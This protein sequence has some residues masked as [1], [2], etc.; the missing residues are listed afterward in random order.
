MSGLRPRVGRPGADGRPRRGGMPAAHPPRRQD[1]GS[2]ALI[3]F[4]DPDA[5]VRVAALAR[6]HDGLTGVEVIAGADCVVLRA[7][8]GTPVDQSAWA[9][10]LSEVL[11][12]SQTQAYDPSAT[13]ALSIDVAY[14]GEDLTAVASATG[15]SIAEV[16]TRHSDAEYLAAFAGFAPGFTYLTGLDPLLALP[17]RSTP[18]TSVPAGSVAIAVGYSAVYP[19]PS[20]GGWH[21]LGHTSAVLFDPRGNPPALI[22][23][24][25]RVRF[26]A[27][28]PEVRISD[29]GAGPVTDSITAPT[30]ASPT[31]REATETSEP[32]EASEPVGSSEPAKPAL[33]VISAGPLAL[34]VDAG[35]PGWADSG[36]GRSGAYDLGALADANAAVGNAADAAAIEV[37]LGPLRF[38]ALDPITVAV[39]G[40]AELRVARRDGGPGDDAASGLDGGAT[41]P[42]AQS[43]LSREA[44]TIPAGH[45][46][47]VRVPSPGVRAYLTV[48]GG[49]DAEPVLGSR[50]RDTLAALG[51]A[52]LASADEI[53]VDVGANSANIADRTADG[54]D[55]GREVPSG[56]RARPLP[57]T[58]PAHSSDTVSTRPASVTLYMSIG[59]DA[60]DAPGIVDAVVGAEWVVSPACDR[61]G[62]RLRPARPD[63]TDEN[64]TETGASNGAWP[65][66]WRDRPSRPAFR[67]CV[68]LPPD[69]GPIILGPDAPTT[70]GYP[71]IGILDSASRDA[72]AQLRPGTRV[73]LERSD[74]GSDADVGGVP[75]SRVEGL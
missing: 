8:P 10:A 71:V 55:I 23:P 69:G 32:V 49:F 20:P 35:R 12:T 44:V 26:R 51:P 33:R 21:L 28:R 62:L 41:Q 47:E 58:G 67:G 16:V 37:T 39:G 45:F 1:F 46:A 29:A 72:C 3:E 74:D 19:R 22:T 56:A 27:V 38:E 64:G 6:A 42:P 24:G 40:P 68:Q 14:D 17:R 34:F 61:I 60:D 18:R 36:V 73:R 5:V 59:P 75:P 30:A 9:S 50:S 57:G 63:V 52:P 53:C 65:D 66:A 48:R 54:A 70:G 2:D 7:L 13:P 43:V 25:T 15:L 31:G 11:R 4:V